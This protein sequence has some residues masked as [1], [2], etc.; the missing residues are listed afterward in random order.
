MICPQ[1]GANVADG[2]RFCSICG[3]EMPAVQ[4]AAAAPTEQAY[5][6]NTYSAPA[7]GPRYNYSQYTQPQPAPQPMPMPQP[8][9]DPNREP[10]SV[11]Q[12]LLTMIVFAIPIVGF[13]MMLVWSFSSNVNRNRKNF[14]LA[15]FIMWLIGIALSVLIFVL[16]GAA[17]AAVVNNISS[18]GSSFGY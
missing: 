2:N 3:A 7:P 4:P 13:I 9:A 12:F 17:I 8:P 10:L 16:A 6:R 15:S 11:G 18:S 1:C 5:S 14:A